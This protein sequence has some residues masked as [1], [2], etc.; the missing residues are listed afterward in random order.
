MK[1]KFVLDSC[2]WIEIQRKSECILSI[3]APFIQLNQVCLVDAIVAEVLR[4]AK[5]EADYRR[6]KTAFSD[7]RQLSTSWKTVTELAFR[8]GRSGFHPPLIDLY[9]AQTVWENDKT[10]ITQD[11]HFLQIARVQPIS[12]MM[13]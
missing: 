8:V 5:S 9:I 12:V 7:F 4:G 10:L 6:L 2:I 13:V 3:V 1:D 11:K